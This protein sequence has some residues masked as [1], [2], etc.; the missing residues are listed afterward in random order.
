M[1]FDDLMELISTTVEIEYEDAAESVPFE[2]AE[3]GYQMTTYASHEL[4]YELGVFSSSD[5]LMEDIVD[6]LPDY[7][8]VE[9]HPFSLSPYDSLAYGWERFC[10]LV[11]HETRFMFFPPRQRDEYAHDDTRPEDMLDEVGSL[12]REVQCISTIRSGTTLFRVR[13]HGPDVAP[14]GLGDLGPPPV[15]LAKF[16]NR[17]SPAGI[18]LLYVSLEAETASAETLDRRL[19]RKSLVTTGLLE[20]VEDLCVLDL[21]KMPVVPNVFDQD[22]SREVRHGIAFMHAFTRDLTKPVLKD[23]A[24]HIDYVPS[25]IVTEYFRY[26]F[27]WNERALD[28]I[29]YPSAAR[30]G[31]TSAVLFF[32]PDECMPTNVL[33][34]PREPPF[35]LVSRTTRPLRGHP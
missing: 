4:L 24:E 23:G 2:S 31:G 13:Q 25:Q 28:G 15:E 27:V 10:R 16:S 34:V 7:S 22:Y 32:G 11:K 17:M 3:G 6:G 5:K 30:I 33:G 9:R 14:H 1:P 35:R 12:V 19:R 29:L 26:R 18:S 20:P 8:W 21:T